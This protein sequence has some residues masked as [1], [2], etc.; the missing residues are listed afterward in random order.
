MAFVKSTSTLSSN[1][2]TVPNLTGGDNGKVV[3]VSG[4]N[5]A[6]NAAN[7]D[8]SSQLLAVLI[9]IGGEYYASGVVSGFSSLTPGSPYYLGTTGD[10]VSAPPTPT[11]ATR[12]LL[13][14]FAL[15]TTDIVLRPG[16]P[17]SG[18]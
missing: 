3:R 1:A 12:A 9:K 7:T 17:I 18:T 14:G 6:V 8:T 16:I 15:N 13:I 5:T 10:L 4:S 2:V 11:T